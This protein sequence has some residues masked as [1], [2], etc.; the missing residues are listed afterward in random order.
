V[1]LAGLCAAHTINATESDAQSK[2]SAPSLAHLTKFVGKY[3]SGDTD[4]NSVKG[5]SLIDDQAFRQ[6]LMKALGKE[7]FNIFIS[8]LHV[9]IPIEQKGQ[10]IYFQKCMPHNCAFFRAHIFINLSDNSIEAYWHNADDKQYYW[11]S[12]KKKPRII[13]ELRGNDFSIFEKYGNQ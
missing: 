8:D 1:I 6:V 2:E 11:L 3:P 10:I 12:S 7:R 9:E 5:K 4:G 13:Q